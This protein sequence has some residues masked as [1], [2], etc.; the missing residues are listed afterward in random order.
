[1]G[2]TAP[3]MTLKP[4]PLSRETPG[5]GRLVLS[6]FRR[7]QR[8][9]RI[10]WARL[11]SSIFAFR[12]ETITRCLKGQFWPLSPSRFIRFG[13]LGSSLHRKPEHPRA[14]DEGRE[15]VSAESANGGDSIAAACPPGDGGICIRCSPA[16][17]PA[18]WSASALSGI[19][20]EAAAGKGAEARGRRRRRGAVIHSRRVAS[21]SCDRRRGRSSPCI[22]LR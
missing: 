8:N 4:S 6:P 3:K 14:G 11:I 2:G 9:P 22:C 13:D 1:M 20:L 17:Y 18:T 21:C 7:S 16:S 10:K 5:T 15:K 19:R 12:K